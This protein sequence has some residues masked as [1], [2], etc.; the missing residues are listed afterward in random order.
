M[1]VT[2]VGTS[3]DWPQW[4]GPNRDGH[5]AEVGL[6]TNWPADG[7][8][9]AW[10]NLKIG[11]GYGSPVIVGDKLYIM[12]GESN[13]AGAAEW[14]VCL[15]STNGKEIWRT[16]LGTS[17]GKFN[18]GW[19]GGPRGT[20]TIAG[21]YLYVVGA[22]G[23]L[24]CLKTAN[25]TK[26]WSK[27]FVKDF[28]GNIPTWGYSESVLVDGNNLICTPGG[29][30]GAIVALDAATGK[31]VWT[32]TDLQ[33]GAGYSS[34]VPTD[35]DGTRFYIQQTGSSGVAVRA[36]DGKLMFKVSSIARK[37]A[38]IPSPV[39]ADGYVFFTAGYG[40][41]CECYKLVGDGK[42]GLKADPVFTKFKTFQNHHGGVLAVGDYIYGH[43]DSGGWTCFAYKQDKDEAVWNSGKLGKGSVT[44]ADGH[45]L[46]YAEKT[47]ELAIVK[48]SPEG[49][50]E[51]GRM[52][53][54]KKSPTDKKDG[55]IW[56]HP[57]I[58]NGKLYLRDYDYLFAFDLKK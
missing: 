37:V 22:T 7:P 12:G 24:L 52:K 13:T 44:Y 9:L 47:G 19:G 18:T 55:A 30:K 21:E 40:A 11:I 25:G 2:A 53:L 57:V 28:G 15:N 10:E 14:V 48:A 58:A 23:D 3:N 50:N 36:I 38:V 8:K 33:D 27:N 20:P 32:T 46:C 43:S 56:A 41:G 5:S 54:P 6:F 31:T 51:V 1:G 42:G 4:R 29:K 35:V 34:I 16:P 17:A 45:L 39:V 26:V 49:W